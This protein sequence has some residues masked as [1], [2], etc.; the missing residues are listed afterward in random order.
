[1]RE[2]D[3]W[4]RWKKGAEEEERWV[5]WDVER[6]ERVGA[7]HEPRHDPFRRARIARRRERLARGRP[8]W[9]VAQAIK[10]M[11]KEDKE[12]W[13]K[14]A[15]EDQ[16]TTPLGVKMLFDKLDSD[17]NGTLSRREVI[18]GARVLKITEAAAERIF[19]KLDVDGNGELDL[20]EFTD[21]QR[22]RQ[23]PPAPPPKKILSFAAPTKFLK[24]KHWLGMPRKSTTSGVPIRILTSEAGQ[25]LQLSEED[26]ARLQ[27]RSETRRKVRARFLARKKAEGGGGQKDVTCS[28][29]MGYR[30]R[31][32]WNGYMAAMLI[33]RWARGVAARRRLRIIR[34]EKSA[35]E[36]RQA[37]AVLRRMARGMWGRRRFWAV[38]HL[39]H[40]SAIF[41]QRCWRSKSIRIALWKSIRRHKAADMIRRNWYVGAE[42]GT[43]WVVPSMP[44]P[45]RTTT[46]TISTTATVPHHQ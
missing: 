10:A 11:E 36:R 44:P 8:E 6:R 17:K 1:M 40:T 29:E 2:L 12:K 35:L 15:K 39:K 37:A 24:K 38:Y 20:Q 23:E 45:A 5:A 21:G 26:L 34:N 22:G 4:Q 19:D 7:S 46:N 9:E 30:F 14:Q 3:Q 31:V 13:E 25:K 28:Q 33:Q 16:L 32:W 43:G 18:D 27:A 41:V 42:R